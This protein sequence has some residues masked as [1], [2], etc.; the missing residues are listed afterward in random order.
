[1]ASPPGGQSILEALS[2]LGISDIERSSLKTEQPKLTRHD[3][4]VLQPAST[5]IKVEGQITLLSLPV[6]IRIE[7]YDLLLASRHQSWPNRDVYKMPQR[8][9]V[10][11]VLSGPQVTTMHPAILRSC[12]Q[13]YDEALP[14]LYA[15]NILSF[16]V[17][18]E[19]FRFVAQIGPRNVKLLKSLNIRVALPAEIS[20]WLELLGVLSNEATGLRYIRIGRYATFGPS[21]NPERAPQRG[22][23]DNLLF[24]RALAKIKGLDT[25]IINGFYAK[26]WPSY[27][28]EM[29]GVQ[30]QVQPG[31][32]I[33]MIGTKDSAASELREMNMLRF[34]EYQEGTEDLIP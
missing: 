26:N 24:V 16:S 7:I 15:R 18:K 9:V 31:L 22:L 27:L 8:Q 4:N 25:L 29:V 19:M 11:G 5:A 34:A 2:D 13:I 17:P 23:G 14:V 28:T 21:Q 6:E 33:A 12:K 1:M 32:Q 3:P 10:L 20:P 30:V